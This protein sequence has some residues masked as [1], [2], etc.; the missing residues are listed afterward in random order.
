[1]TYEIGKDSR[2]DGNDEFFDRRLRAIQ[3]T[4][5]CP[6]STRCDGASNFQ[7]EALVELRIATHPERTFVLDSRTAS[8]EVSWSAHGARTHRIPVTHVDAPTWGYG[9]SIDL[10]ATTA[11]RADG[12]YAPGSDV[13]YRITL[14]DGAG[15]PLHPEGA[16]P[17]YN[18]VVF[19]TNEPGIQ[20]YR[21]FFDPT[22]T[23]YRRKHRERMLM[24]QIIGPAQD[25]QAVRSIIDI[26]AF[27]APDDV[28]TTATMARDGV[29]AQFRTIPTSHDLFGGNWDAPVSDSWS[30]HLPDDAK[31][32]TYLVD[33]EGTK[34]VPRRG[35][36]VL[37]H[38]RD[39]GR[40]AEPYRGLARYRTVQQ[41]P[42]RPLGARQGS[43]R[44]RQP[45]GVQLVSRAA[46]VRARRSHLRPHALHPLAI[47]P[48][49]R[50]A[51]EVFDVPSHEGERVTHQQG[52]VSVLS[53]VLSAVSRPR[54]R[55]C[56]EH[57]R[58]RWSRVL[59][60]VHDHLPYEPS[61]Q[62]PA[63]TRPPPQEPL[64]A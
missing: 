5:D 60:L 56:R 53:Q 30:Y 27:L 31:A 40:N 2:R 59:R 42:Q 41:L 63:L 32:G 19:G 25:I 57:V 44:Q 28:Q 29:Y 64:D 1:M 45:R 26:E 6:T 8:L 46:R 38:G 37:A 58:R 43:P 10:K 13:G 17:T 21:A 20:Y 3:W 22:T 48:C 9:F 16:L 7:E 14:K 62:R 52:G 4:F 24:S 61:R 11:P 23:Y 33:G 18:E 50:A 39:P 35:R 49:R 34:D 55:P 54:F 47:E 51:H 12:T 36:A 15:K